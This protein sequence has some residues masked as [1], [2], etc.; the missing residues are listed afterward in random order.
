MLGLNLKEYREK[1]AQLKQQLETA[2]EEQQILIYENLAA[3]QRY[4]L[5]EPCRER[6]R[7]YLRQLSIG[8]TRTNPNQQRLINHAKEIPE[9]NKK[10]K[11]LPSAGA[12]TLFYSGLGAFKPI[13]IIAKLEKYLVVRVRFICI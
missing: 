13:R 7:N 9:K 11:F 1:I 3:G 2:A 12:G 8:D 10:E 5:R 4:R 6:Y